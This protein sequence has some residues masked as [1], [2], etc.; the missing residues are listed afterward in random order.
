MQKIIKK[1]DIPPKKMPR[2]YS[3]IRAIHK[4]RLYKSNIKTRDKY[5]RKFIESYFDIPE[6]RISASNISPGQLIMFDYLEPKTEEELEYYDARPC[7]IFF[8][9]FETENGTRVIGFNLHYFPP[10]YRWQILDRILEIF[11]PVYKKMWTQN[12]KKSMPYFTY[13]FLFYQIQAAKL[14]F[15]VRMYIPELISNIIPIP[16]SGWEKASLTEGVFRKRTRDAIMNYW[17]NKHKNTKLIKN[18]EKHGV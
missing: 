16:A 15:G 14:D 3:L 4:D 2:N 17:K 5:A 10:K 18:I 13:R 6:K 8:G 7:T 9:N 11:R 1:S 12:I